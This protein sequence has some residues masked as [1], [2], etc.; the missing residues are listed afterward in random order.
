MSWRTLG[1][2]EPNWLEWRDLTS[3]TSAV[4]FRIT[5][6]FS[7]DSPGTG[8]VQITAIYTGAGRYGWA[9]S[10]PDEE[11]KVFTMRPSRELEGAGFTERRISIRLASRSRKIANANWQVK[12]E[13]WTGPIETVPDESNASVLVELGNLDEEVGN[14]TNASN[15][16]Y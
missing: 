7:G 4:L 3:I 8:P 12:V 15:F 6:S 10:W 2:V 1:T 14:L 13:E 9:E 16:F 11:P 5:H